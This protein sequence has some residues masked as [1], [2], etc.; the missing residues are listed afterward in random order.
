MTNRMLRIDA[1]RLGPFSRL[2]LKSTLGSDAVF[3]SER[4]WLFGQTVRRV[5]N[6]DFERTQMLNDRS[7]WLA[8]TTLGPFLTLI[9]SLHCR[10]DYF[11][12]STRQSSLVTARLLQSPI[13]GSR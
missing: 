12:H 7:S 2:L 1:T 11:P 3:C 6:A 8:G 9:L 5:V 10:Q 4:F 13:H